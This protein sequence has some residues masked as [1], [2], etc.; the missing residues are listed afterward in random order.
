LSVLQWGRGDEA[1][2]EAI[3]PR[4]VATNAAGFNGAAAMKPRKSAAAQT[5]LTAAGLLQWGRGNEA[6]EEAMM[7]FSSSSLP[8]LQWGRGNEAAEEVQLTKVTPRP[9]RFN[10]AA[11]MKPR[12]RLKRE[13]RAEEYGM[14]Q[15]GRGNEAAEESMG[16]VPNLSYRV[17]SMGPRQ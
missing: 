8:P 7:A 3:G 2:E 12:K 9:A 4:S 5:L 6:A 1:A 13:G 14:L 17:A 10:G 11:A 16:A 15:W